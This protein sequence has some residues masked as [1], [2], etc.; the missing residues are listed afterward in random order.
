MFAWRGA[1]SGIWAAGAHGAQQ[2]R[3][4][5]GTLPTASGR[6]PRLEPQLR[7]QAAGAAARVGR[8]AGARGRARQQRAAVRI[9]EVPDQHL[10]DPNPK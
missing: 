6:R 8:G 4:P 1:F 3:G 7:A 2:R 5:P 9:R 10:R